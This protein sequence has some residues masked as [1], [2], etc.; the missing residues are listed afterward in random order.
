MWREVSKMDRLLIRHNLGPFKLDW[1][2]MVVAHWA[3]QR[4]ADQSG[5]IYLF[6]NAKE[7]KGGK[8]TAP[9]FPRGVTTMSGGGGGRAMTVLNVAEKPSVAKSVS[10]LLSR[11]QGLRVREGRSR[12]NKV[13][14]FEYSIRGQPCHMMMTSVTGHVTELDF[15]E[16][17]RKW[18]SCDPADLFHAPIRKSVPQVIRFN[19]FSIRCFLFGIWSWK[20]LNQFL[21]LGK[22]SKNVI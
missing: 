9:R 10:T 4:G 16:R 17:F 5:L 8:K 3:H 21:A 12:Y 15:D 7:R 20:S 1:S 19:Y 13:F 14:E 11:N 18:N 6:K 2:I 22:V